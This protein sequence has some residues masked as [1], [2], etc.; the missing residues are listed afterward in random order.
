MTNNLDIIEIFHTCTEDEKLRIIIDGEIKH[1]DYI[2][3]FRIFPMKFHFNPDLMA[4]IL[5]LKYVSSLRGVNITTDTSKERA[6]T[7]SLVYG[8]ILKFK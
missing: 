8:G 2:G 4:T 3:C 5:S 1:Y 7:V 6:I